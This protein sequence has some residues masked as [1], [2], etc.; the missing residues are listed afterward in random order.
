MRYKE[1]L[2]DMKHRDVPI[3]FSEIVDF[4]KG[5]LKDIDLSRPAKVGEHDQPLSPSKMDDSAESGL[6]KGTVTA[7]ITFKVFLHDQ[8]QGMSVCFCCSDRAFECY[9]HIR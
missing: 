8:H 1:N 9:D 6:K 4:V 5:R 7:E 3:K 2:L